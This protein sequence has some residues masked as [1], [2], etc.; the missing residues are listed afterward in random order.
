MADKSEF[1]SIATA[2]IDAVY[3]TA[4]ALCNDHQQAE[5]LVQTTYLKAFEQFGSFKSGTNCKAWL[6]RILRNKW[7]DQLRHNR[8][9]GTTLPIEEAIVADPNGD[10]EVVWNDCEDLLE[11]FSDEQVIGALKRLPEEQRLTLFLIDVEQLSQADVA[12][13]MGVAIGTVKSRA[14]RAR[15][16]L[17]KNLLPYAEKLGFVRRQT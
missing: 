14:S 8:V 7:I 5:D 11:K 16:A 13:I 6:L 2:H 12:E 9:V 3:R 10:K 15:A 17:K 4:F 1:E